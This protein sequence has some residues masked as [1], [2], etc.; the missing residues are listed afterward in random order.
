MSDQNQE[1]RE[2]NF[3]DACASVAILTIVIATVVYWLSGMPS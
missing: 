1:A 3:A 2:D